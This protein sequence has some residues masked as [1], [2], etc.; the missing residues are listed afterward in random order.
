[1]KSKFEIDDY[2][3]ENDTTRTWKYR[4]FQPSSIE[5]MCVKCNIR[6]QK[7]RTRKGR[8][9]YENLCGRCKNELYS[10]VG[11]DNFAEELKFKKKPYLKYKKDYCEK[12]DFKPVHLIQLE[13][14]HIDGNHS[15]DDPSNLQTL[16]CNC[17][18]LK[19]YLQL[20]EKKPAG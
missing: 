13:V 4:K 5:G 6:K 11:I 14:D 15:N 9:V 2:S 12:C 19:T 16:C 18:R 20:Y 17:H 10:K 1:M 7:K 3:I 8:V